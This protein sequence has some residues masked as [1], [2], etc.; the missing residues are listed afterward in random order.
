MVIDTGRL[1]A[2]SKSQA[3]LIEEL[4][5]ITITVR[6]HGVE[7]K[8]KLGMKTFAQQRVHML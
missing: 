2:L 1:I 4:A 3:G 7:N 8:A 5:V 6:K